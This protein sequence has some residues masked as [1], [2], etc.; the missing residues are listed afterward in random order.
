MFQ[1]KTPKTQEAYK[2]VYVA[3]NPHTASL[4]K[5]QWTDRIRIISVDPGITHYAIR[6][7]ERNTKKNDIITTLLYD[8]IGLKK[9]E[10]ELTADHVTRIFTFVF[11]FLD[12]H[13]DLF[14]TC[15]VVIIEKQ[16]PINYR[17]L[18]MSQH[19]LTYFMIHLKNLEPTLPMF[20]EVMPTLKGRELGAPPNTNEKGIKIWAVEKA[21]ELLTIRNDKVGL[22]I[23][24]RKVAGKREKKDD[25]S[26]VVLQIEA[27]FSH[28][29]WPITTF[30][31]TVNLVP[32]QVKILP[33]I[34]L[35]PDGKPSEKP[36][37]KITDKPKLMILRQ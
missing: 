37:E 4:S 15:H 34:E 12:K 30:I 3:H 24:N 18:R 21:I 14:K 23:L 7:E 32:K 1:R 10:Q 17:A 16:L 13:L 25:L 2:S 5:R 26:D 29:G 11:E 36:S 6:V 19:T 31:P 20:F 33:I 35:N 22:N 27:L 8:K 28:F 9:E